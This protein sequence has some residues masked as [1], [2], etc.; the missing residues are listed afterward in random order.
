MICSSAGTIDSA[1]IEA[2]PLGARIFDIGKLLEGF[3]FDQLVEDCFFAFLSE[4]DV[5]LFTLD[6]LLDPR[7]FRTASRY[8]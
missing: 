2:E 4:G 5:L 1:T 6:P 3:R 8:A 7:F